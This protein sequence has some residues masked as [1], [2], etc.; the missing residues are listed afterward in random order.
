MGLI[1]LAALTLLALLCLLG[2]VITPLGLPG[3]FVILAA[4][5]LYNLI[6]WA[7]A[8]SLWVLVLLLCL[9]L[10][11]EIL[12][13][14]L[15]V[16]MASRRGASNAAIAGALIGGLVGAF[17][18]IPVPVLGSIIGLFLGVFIGA[19]LLEL[20]FKKDVPRAFRAAVGAFYGRAGAILVKTVI[21]LA[22]MIIIAAAV[23]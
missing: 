19:F 12:E 15:S 20:I 5:L 1:S 3:T 9:A 4:A 7:M 16:R 18:G 22:M 21:G 14:G 23:F 10:L 11:G 6:H 2:L 13:Y 8:I 17:A